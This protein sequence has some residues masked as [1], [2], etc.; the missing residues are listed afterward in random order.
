MMRWKW[1]VR[2][3]R[4]TAGPGRVGT[5]R[6][7]L[8]LRG[9]HPLLIFAFLVSF[10]LLLPLPLL[11]QIW[12]LKPPPYTHPPPHRLPTHQTTPRTAHHA[13]A[14]ERTR[15]VHEAEHV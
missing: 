12:T 5:Q 4:A 13:G 1:A 15:V 7:A 3:A 10:L 9:A 2:G 11:L 8:A 14:H 6:D